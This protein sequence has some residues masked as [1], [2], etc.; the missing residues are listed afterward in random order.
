V[1]DLAAL[2]EPRV[3]K[4]RDELLAVAEGRKVLAWY[5]MNRAQVEEYT[6]LDD[7]M[8]A[9]RKLD[10]SVVVRARPE[11]VTHP[12]EPDRDV[13]VVRDAVP[14]QVEAFRACQDVLGRYD[15]SDSSEYMYSEF[16]GYAPEECDA[17]VAECRRNRL[18]WRGKTLYGLCDDSQ[19]GQLRATA[20]R[21]FPESFDS[22]SFLVFVTGAELVL[23]RELE[24]RIPHGRTLVRFAV[25]YESYLR[26]FSGASAAGGVRSVQLGM[27]PAALNAVLESHIEAWTPDGWQRL[28]AR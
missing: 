1:E 4:V 28:V 20:C 11:P 3:V 27:P 21:C 8:D 14:W 24:G 23:P 18:G 7:L 6:E 26:L 2:F 25:E 15:W 19:V 13:F 16:L 9:A 22:A 12:A 17:W 10:L 5:P